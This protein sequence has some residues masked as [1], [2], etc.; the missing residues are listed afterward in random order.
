MT[1]PAWTAAV[2][3]LSAIGLAGSLILSPPPTIEAAVRSVAG[4]P[5]DT[6]VANPAA[7]SIRWKGA[8]S[9][10]REGTVTL[11]SGMFVIRHQRLTSGDFVVDLRSL[12]GALRN[13]DVFDVEHYP[14][15]VVRTSEMTRIGPAAWRIAGTLT[16]RGVTKPIVFDT[17]V[18]WPE[19]GHMV[20]TSTF[21]IDQREWAAAYRPA[22]GTDDG[23]QLSITLDA[24]RKQASVATR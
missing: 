13:P 15:A 6:L 11:A 24:H 9:G 12:D 10:A 3:A 14:T 7:S 21:T 17:D 19:L 1:T 23:L 4:G 22:G 20:A 18:A 8:G 5:P 16:M 2:V